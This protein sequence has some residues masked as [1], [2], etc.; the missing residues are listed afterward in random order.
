[1]K[2]NVRIKKIE[3]ELLDQISILNSE[4]FVV[5]WP[6]DTEEEKELKLQN[7]LEELNRK[8]GEDVSRRDIIIMNVIYDEPAISDKYY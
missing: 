7:L 8:Y 3:R 1:M 6:N 5:I 4:R 2:I